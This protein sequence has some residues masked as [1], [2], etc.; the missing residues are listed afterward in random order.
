[1]PIQGRAPTVGQ[2]PRGAVSYLRLLTLT[3]VQ[4][5]CDNDTLTSLP[6]GRRTAVPSPLE[7]PGVGGGWVPIPAR[8]R[9][10][11]GTRQLGTDNA[12]RTRPGNRGEFGSV[13]SLKCKESAHPAGNP[14]RDVLGQEAH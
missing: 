1:M 10:H 2:N 7:S 5:R 11:A 14:S 9:D 8:P 3:P 13:Q 4:P 6:L 12:S